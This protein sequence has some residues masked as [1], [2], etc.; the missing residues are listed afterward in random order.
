MYSVVIFIITVI[1]FINTCSFTHN[2]LGGL[3]ACILHSR[4]KRKEKGRKRKKKRKEERKMKKWKMSSSSSKFEKKTSSSSGEARTSP[5]AIQLRSRVFKSNPVPTQRFQKQSSY[6]SNRQE[7]VQ[8][9]PVHNSKSLVVFSSKMKW[10]GSLLV[11]RC[12]W[13]SWVGRRGLLAVWLAP[14][15]RVM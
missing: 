1:L 3:H 13:R 4:D 7:P 12:F 8:S 9:N 10:C 2:Q 14:F 11:C 6:I 5:K 15:D